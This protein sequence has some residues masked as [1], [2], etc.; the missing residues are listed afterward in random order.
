MIDPSDPK[1][2][3]DDFAALFAASSRTRRLER[4]QAVDGTIVAIGQDV[5]FVDVGG[6]GEATIALDELKND[7]G[8]VEFKAG[9]RIQATVMSTA[10]ELVLSRKLQ[11][12]AASLRQV[13]D[14]YRAG[15]P[16]EGLVAGLV[17]GG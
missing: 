9:D 17:K 15:L 14:A 13:E 16:V 1:N 2:P 10:G 11:R 5:A 8:D 6:K 4:G 3:E 12:G 7:A